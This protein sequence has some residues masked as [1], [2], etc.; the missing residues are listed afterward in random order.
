MGEDDVELNVLKISM[1]YI[2]VDV[3]WGVKMCELCDLR[4]GYE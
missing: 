2:T 3:F 1:N 4:W